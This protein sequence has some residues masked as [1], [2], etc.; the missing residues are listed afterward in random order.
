M[1]LP[2]AHDDSATSSFS[3]D[4]PPAERALRVVAF[5]EPGTA[6][7]LIEGSV[8]GAAVHEFG[9]AMDRAVRGHERRLVVDVSRVDQ[10]SL[11]AQA[12]ILAASRAKAVRGEQLVLRGPSATL[13]E[14]SR[15]LGLLERV[16]TIDALPASTAHRG[17][18]V[19]SAGGLTQSA[20]RAA[21]A[22]GA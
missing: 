11:V 21:P 20:R 19:P 9:E 1:D 2:F 18:G 4:G 15:R 5:W 22:P 7:L 3:D 16:V 6:F 17:E 12:L 14:Q 8:Q 13:R 10:W